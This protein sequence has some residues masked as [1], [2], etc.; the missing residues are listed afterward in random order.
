MDARLPQDDRLREIAS[1]ISQNCLRFHQSRFIQ[2]IPVFIFMM[3]IAG[4][5]NAGNEATAMIDI[6]VSSHQPKFAIGEPA[7]IDVV[8]ANNEGDT[9]RVKVNGDWKDTLAITLEH[10]GSDVPR[11]KPVTYSGG[12][13]SVMIK[14]FAPGEKME[15]SIVLNELFSIRDRGSYVVE[16]ALIANNVE[17]AAKTSFTIASVDTAELE[18]KYQSVLKE[19]L[20]S[21][22]PSERKAH[23]ERV[24]CLSDNPGALVAQRQVFERRRQLSIGDLSYLTS[25][26]V[27]TRSP[28][29]IDSMLKQIVADDSDRNTRKIFFNA[30]R[31]E[32]L[33]NFDEKTQSSLNPYLQEIQDGVPLDISD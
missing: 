10:H 2:R 25:A 14:Q 29:V 9:Q 30:I 17:R 4:L 13:S 15:V 26:M 5:L 6:Q 20:D 8:L 3:I 28:D 24:I 7:V 23:L 16:V 12:I 33:N 27:K 31:V 21:D 22:T 19:Y 1:K 18:A 11:N 32:G